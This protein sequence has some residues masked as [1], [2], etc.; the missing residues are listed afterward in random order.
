LKKVLEIE[1]LS[2]LLFGTGKPFST[3]SAA[4]SAETQAMPLPTTIAGGV[5]SEL[6]RQ[7][8]WFGGS[9]KVAELNEVNFRGPFMRIA[10]EWYFPS[11]SDCAAVKVNDVSKNAACRPRD[12]DG[13]FLPN[14]VKPTSLPAGDLEPD[15]REQGG[16]WSA[17]D[18]FKWLGN[19]DC[20]IYDC[21]EAR[22]YP[23]TEIRTHVEIDPDRRAH[24]KGQLFQTEGV[25]SGSI[26]VMKDEVLEK[27]EDQRI[28][29]EYDETEEFDGCKIGAIT[30]GGERRLAIANELPDGL[31]EMPDNLYQAMSETDLIRLQLATPGLFEEGWK[32][33]LANIKELTGI[34][35]EL[36]SACVGRRIPRAG[37]DAVKRGPRKLKWLAPAGSV[38]FLKCKKGEGE[39]L[40]DFW[41]KSM[42]DDDEGRRDGYALALWGVWNYAQ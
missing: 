5:R 34:D 19:A 4:L 40:K 22:S 15:K 24:K 8:G 7:K 23:P 39:K 29:F 3:E 16:L 13:S 35:F 25:I 14:G 27:F 10:G 9:D 32:P 30:L 11:P 31:P 28:V 38:Y 33:N 17:T 18:T 42:A 21:G 1:G 36:V 41:L 37:W 2:P 20:K 26:A 12:A 6:A